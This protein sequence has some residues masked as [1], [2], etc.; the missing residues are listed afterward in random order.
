MRC[1]V[2]CLPGNTRALQGND[3]ADDFLSVIVGGI[4]AAAV[5][6]GLTDCALDSCQ[7]MKRS[8]HQQ[9]RPIRVPEQRW[10]S[11]LNDRVVVARV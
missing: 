6:M 9:P 10:R 5:F 1:H 11:W 3:F 8:A 7:K 2:D 4:V